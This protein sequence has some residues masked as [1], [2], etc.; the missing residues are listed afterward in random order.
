MAPSAESVSRKVSDHM[1]SNY[2]FERLR[3]DKVPRSYVGVRA[4]Q[5]GR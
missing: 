1:L 4:A 3:T 5:R 2:A